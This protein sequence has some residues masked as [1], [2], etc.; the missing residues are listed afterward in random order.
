[1]VVGFSR[2]EKKKLFSGQKLFVNIAFSGVNV[3][4]SQNYAKQKKKK[5]LKSSSKISFENI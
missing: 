5:K 2:F 3:I 1:M 4:I